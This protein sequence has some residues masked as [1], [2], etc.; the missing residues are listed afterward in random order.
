MELVTEA[1]AGRGLALSGSWTE[2]S[3]HLVRGDKAGG[4][5]QGLLL[6]APECK[7]LTMDSRRL[8]RAWS[9]SHL[10]P[11]AAP[12]PSYGAAAIA[13]PQ[14]A[15]LQSCSPS[16][17]IHLGSYY[18]SSTSPVKL[19]SQGTLMLAHSMPSFPPSHPTP[20]ELPPLPA[21]PKQKLLGA[22]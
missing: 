20:G 8:S 5:H 13:V 4:R 16:V 10:P 19:S 6:V 3:K 9:S 2:R 18:P 11:A 7:L 17:P 12:L 15:S 22:Y 1:D 21:L 14:D